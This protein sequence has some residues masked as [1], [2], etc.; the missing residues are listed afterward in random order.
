MEKNN[1][2]LIVTDTNGVVLASQAEE[3]V[4]Y[5]CP[6]AELINSDHQLFEASN[7]LYLDKRILNDIAFQQILSNNPTTQEVDNILSNHVRQ[8]FAIHVWD[9]N[10]PWRLS[11][12]ESI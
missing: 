8:P 2:K 10:I 1:L 5:C 11:Y 4:G 12:T 6:A 3:D 9:E 7:L